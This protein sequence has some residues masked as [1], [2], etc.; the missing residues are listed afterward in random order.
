MGP[1]TWD[2]FANLPPYRTMAYRTNQQDNFEPNEGADADVDGLPD[3]VIQLPSALTAKSD[4]YRYI[5][6]PL[7][8]DFY[9]VDTTWGGNIC[10]RAPKNRTY[11]LSIYATKDKINT[12]TLAAGGDGQPDGGLWEG[13]ASNGAETCWYGSLHAP[14]RHGEYKFIVGIRSTDG[15]FSPHWP[16][17]LKVPK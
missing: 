6:A 12:T 17:W 3:E 13:E 10:L 4:L 8:D 15:D 5:S 16:Y 9:I 7:D 2:K 11:T 1:A 14:P